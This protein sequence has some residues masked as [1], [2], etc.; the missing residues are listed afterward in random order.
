MYEKRSRKAAIVLWFVFMITIAGI[1]FLS[2]ENGE[3]SK[4]LGEHII[5]RLALARHPGVPATEAELLWVTYVIRQLA[6]VFAFLVIGILGTV[7]V[8][9]SMKNTGWI[10]KTLI[11]GGILF[12]VAYFTEELKKYIPS[13]HYSHKE[14]MLSMAAVAAGFLFV[15]FIALLKQGI[16]RIV[17]LA[18]IH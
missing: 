1:A 14:M 2:F 3:R 9:V 6:R 15:S 17:Q 12:A 18:E 13:R 7:T 11:S 16:K 10:V 8:H 4:H 5:A